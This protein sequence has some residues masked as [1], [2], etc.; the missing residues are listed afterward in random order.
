MQLLL[1]QFTPPPVSISLFVQIFSSAP[2]SH[3]QSIFLPLCKKPSF[4]PYRT[5]SKI[6]VLYILNSMFFDRRREDIR[7]WTEAK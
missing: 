7:L 5:T 1:V 4:T 6:I 3:S 2:C